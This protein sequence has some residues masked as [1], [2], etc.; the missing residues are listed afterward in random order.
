[1]FRLDLGSFRQ[2]QTRIAKLENALYL[3]IIAPYGLE[4]ENNLQKFMGRES[5]DVI[6]FDLGPLLQG[7]TRVAKLI[8]AKTCLLVFL[9]FW[10]VKLSER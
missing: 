6:R 3:L 7:Q 2:G 8:S 1:M 4:C 9:E 5:S 10:V